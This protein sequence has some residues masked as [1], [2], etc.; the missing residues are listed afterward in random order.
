[1]RGGRVYLAELA[2]DAERTIH[3]RAFRAPVTADAGGALRFDTE[4]KT[5][6]RK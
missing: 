5:P 2:L 4:R 6:F 1:L 3:A